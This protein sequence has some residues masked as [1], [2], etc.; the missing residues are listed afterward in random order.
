MKDGNN[1]FENKGTIYLKNTHVG[2][3]NKKELFG[4]LF[5][6]KHGVRVALGDEYI[7]IPYINI[8]AIRE[9]KHNNVERFQ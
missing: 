5:Y 1:L 8:I 3:H 2:L 4:D 9:Q 7:T 6:R